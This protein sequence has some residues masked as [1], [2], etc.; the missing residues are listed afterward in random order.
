MVTGNGV[1]VS[2]N[3]SGFDVIML[4][5]PVGNSNYTS[6]FPVSYQLPFL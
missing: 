6:P 3:G 5:V 4:S 1:C 2:I